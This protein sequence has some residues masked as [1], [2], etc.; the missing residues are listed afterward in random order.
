MSLSTSSLL[1]YPTHSLLANCVTEQ[2]IVY[3]GND[4]NVGSSNIQPDVESCRSSCHAMGASHFTHDQRTPQAG[5]WCKNSDAGRGTS[6]GEISGDTA[7][8]NFKVN[9]D[10]SKR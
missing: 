1:S 7:C 3:S 6:V 4:V 5:C 8:K 10:I 9:G 2:D